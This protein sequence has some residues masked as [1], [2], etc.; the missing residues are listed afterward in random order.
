ME[1]VWERL[2]RVMTAGRIRAAG[3]PVLAC[4]V[5]L[6]SILEFFYQVV[7]RAFIGF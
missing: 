7:S 6:F 1:P 4:T 2:I 5:S 3:H